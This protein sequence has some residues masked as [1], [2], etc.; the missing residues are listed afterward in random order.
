MGHNILLTV[1]FGVARFG[2]GKQ[3]LASLTTQI[4]KTAPI[5]RHPWLIFSKS[6]T[7]R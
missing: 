7:W 2:C 3:S 1:S 6:R 4:S 5:Q